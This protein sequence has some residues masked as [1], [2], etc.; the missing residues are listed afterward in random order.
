MSSKSKKVLFSLCLVMTLASCSQQKSVDEYVSAAKI[1]IDDS[2]YKSAIIQLKN[3]IQTDAKHA[4]ARYLLGKLYLLQ[5]N[6]AG[7]VKELERAK[8]YQ[9]SEHEVLPLL[10]NAYYLSEDFQPLTLLDSKNLTQE[11]RVLVKFYQGLAYI[12][13]A[14]LDEA[15]AA[16]NDMGKSS[17]VAGY[18]ALLQGYMGFQE[19]DV[20]QAKKF[21]ETG[22]SLLPAQPQGILLLGHIGSATNNFTLAIEN[23]N[24]YLQKYPNQ[25]SVELMLAHAFLQNGNTLE[26]ERHAD[27]ILTLI[28][29]QAFA[30]YIKAIV[31]AQAKD[32][33]TAHEHAE[34]A[35]N[36]KMNSTNI[37]LVA[38]VSAFYLKN[39][40]RSLNY[41]KPLVKFLPEEHFAR[42]MLLVSQMELGLIEDAANSLDDLTGFSNA[43]AEF[44]SA[45]SYELLQAGAIQDARNLL[46]KQ[47]E[48]E[49][50]D[51]SQLFRDGFLRMMLSDDAAITSLEQAI[52]LDPKLL[53]AEMALAYLAIK[54][55]DIN[56]AQLIAQKWQ[57]E[58][59]EK[60][61]AYQLEAAIAMSRNNLE[62]ANKLLKKALE[63]EPANVATLIKLAQLSHYNNQVEEA[64]TYIN[65]AL[66]VHPYH[67]Q[68]NR[69]YFN[70]HRNDK[71]LN[72]IA[73]KVKEA[74]NDQGL[75][76]VYAEALLKLDKIDESVKVLSRISPTLNTSKLYWVL[77]T[78]AARAAKNSVMLKSTLDEWQR[79]NPYHFE[80]NILLADY[81]VAQKNIDGAIKA[82]N[83]GLEKHQ[84]HLALLLIKTQLLLDAGKVEEANTL[85]LSYR[86]KITGQK[87]HLSIE[88]RI[89][90]L[91]GDYLKAQEYLSAF[92]QYQPSSRN[93]VFFVQALIANEQKKQAI[94]VLTEHIER[95][96]DN[97]RLYS[98]IASLQLSVGNKEQ[99]LKVYKK[100]TE[101]TPQNVVAINNVAWLYMEAGDLTQALAYAEKAVGLAPKI[102]NVVDTYGRILFKLGK[103]REAMPHAKK[104]YDLSK[105]KDLDIALNYVEVLIENKRNNQALTVLNSIADGTKVQNRRKL[106]Y[107]KIINS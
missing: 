87:I 74:P 84:E 20:E 3:G 103:E 34:I 61:E 47:G 36:N 21:V 68:L 82:I 33:E 64:Q 63:I 58:F 93:V 31:R 13:L 78:Y 24:K 89:E 19:Q 96:G 9:Y 46:A 104:A 14:Q 107:I 102:P 81:Y 51:A 55:G 67:Q 72:E 88:G 54:N 1:S 66:E 91:K 52:A 40:E 37:K 28:P 12:K 80:R 11:K 98:L 30:N 83:D 17:N 70:L 75:N 56:K 99:A 44:Y 86:N 59:P 23:Y 90:L 5:D 106:S 92:Y 10:A 42:K 8:K 65:K 7:A 4:E 18:R 71:A 29:T 49:S 26:A 43:D 85:Y 79:V 62:S 76:L 69:F 73:E 105:G 15:K 77:K 22:L 57:K 41:L 48:Q 45:I 50:N 6:V 60:A 94:D 53:K 100:L 101:T 97:V 35:I 39:Y 95:F 2:D 38:G 27:N 25:R 16:L 32:Y